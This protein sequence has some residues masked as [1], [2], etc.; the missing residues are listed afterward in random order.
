MC[1]WV[2]LL[3]ILRLNDWMVVYESLQYA[4]VDAYKFSDIKQMGIYQLRYIPNFL[5]LY[6]YFFNS[7]GFILVIQSPRTWI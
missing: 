7:S 2:Q 3:Y 1:Y 4:V 5:R 6:G